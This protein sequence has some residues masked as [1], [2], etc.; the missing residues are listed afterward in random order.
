MLFR[1][2]KYF[3]SLFFAGLICLS[4]ASYSEQEILEP[5]TL[6]FEEPVPIGLSNI[7]YLVETKSA[8][9][10]LSRARIKTAKGY[11]IQTASGFLPTIRAQQNIEKVDGGQIFIQEQPVNVQRT[12]QTPRVIAEYQVQ[13]GGEL[14]FRVMA[15][16]HEVK[17]NKL[18]YEQS[19]QE[20][21]L[22][23]T[24]EYFDLLRDK[25]LINQASQ[26][27]KEAEALLA[28]Q[29]DRLDEG[30]GM[31]YDVLQAKAT[32]LERNNEYNKSIN[33][34]ALSEVNLLSSLGFTVS[35]SVEPADKKL[36]P[37]QFIEGQMALE[38]WGKIAEME[39]ADLRQLDY[40]IKAAKAIYRS[41][42]SRL[43]PTFTINGYVGGVGP[44]LN[45]LRRVTQG[46]IGFSTDLLR[47]LGVNLFGTIKASKGEIEEAIAQREIQ[48]AQIKKDLA[49]AYYEYQYQDERLLTVEERVNVEEKTLQLAKDRLEAGL[50]IT[51]EITQQEV[52]LAQARADYINTVAAYNKAQL[53]LLYQAGQLT[54]NILTQA[55]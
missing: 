44:E 7:P 10:A 40:E 3:L 35:H 53:N 26:T 9:V 51:L 50:G 47:N 41:N 15:N 27:K 17:G 30:F 34:E 14:L 12:T 8:N 4:S 55:Q 2:T 21:L 22:N 1:Q 19:F 39:R 13:T 16:K 23:V 6:T 31:E 49:T 24:S 5:V 38:N 37:V 45:R 18:F 28:Y 48:L 29:T 11:L 43:M 36:T 46:G 42:F 32:V 20:A 33:Q 25:A 52:K 54:P